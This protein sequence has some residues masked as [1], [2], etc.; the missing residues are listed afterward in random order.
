M[1]GVERRPVP[2]DENENRANLDLNNQGADSTDE[3][4]LCKSM[5]SDTSAR[6]G[7]QEGLIRVRGQKKLG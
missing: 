5:K 6:S 3:P 1:S 7:D 4:G 2:Y